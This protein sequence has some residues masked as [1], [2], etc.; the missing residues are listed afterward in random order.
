MHSLYDEQTCFEWL[1]LLSGLDCSFFASR[2]S[3]AMFAMQVKVSDPRE[4]SLFNRDKSKVFLFVVYWIWWVEGNLLKIKE[5]DWQ[6]ASCVCDICDEADWIVHFLRET[7]TL[8]RMKLR[9]IRFSVFLFKTYFNTPVF[10]WFH[11]FLF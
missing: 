4:F 11:I 7:E 3:L 1:Y 5:L 10:S 2:R 6:R 9:T 8:R